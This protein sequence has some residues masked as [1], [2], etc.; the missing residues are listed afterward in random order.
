MPGDQLLPRGFTFRG[1]RRAKKSTYIEGGCAD[2]G[3]PAEESRT[4][5]M[6]L[7]GNVKRVQLRRRKTESNVRTTSDN[8]SWITNASCSLTTPSES[9]RFGFSRDRSTNCLRR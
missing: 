7:V 1:I 2:H 8:P 4:Q 6:P 9:I 5:C 3:R